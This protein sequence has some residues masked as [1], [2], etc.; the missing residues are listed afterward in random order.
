MHK[1]LQEDK[2]SCSLLSMPLVQSIMYPLA[3]EDSLVLINI[4]LE[5]A[6]KSHHPN[7]AILPHLCISHIY[8]PSI[9]YAVN[10]LGFLNL[11]LYQ[12]FHLHL[13]HHHD[14]I[15]IMT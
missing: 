6:P 9:A 11:T 5:K 4:T 1:M 15:I 3:A 8:F 2:T 12:V 14:Y 7:C 10:T 13:K